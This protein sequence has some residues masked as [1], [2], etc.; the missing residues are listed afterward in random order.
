MKPIHSFDQLPEAVDYLVKEVSQLR[1]LINHQS[2]STSTTS[3]L[4]DIKG[5]ADFLGLSIPTIYG[6]VSRRELPFMKRGN[7]LY[8]DS[9]ELLEY[10]KEGRVSTVN[11][12][13]D[14]PSIY[15]QTPKSRKNA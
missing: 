6:K 7:R 12:I 4:L 11:D 15:L 14:S 2:D 8:F 5:A 10:I 3:K 9:S 13:D 1:L